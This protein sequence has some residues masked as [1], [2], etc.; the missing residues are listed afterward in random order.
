MAFIEVEIDLEDHL[1]EVDSDDLI[2]ELKR[3]GFYVL[4]RPR[5]VIPGKG[6]LYDHLKTEILNEL[7]SFSLKQLES[8]LEKMKASKQLEMK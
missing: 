1:D 5:D 4:N 6:S 8:V 3:R 7:Y 2:L